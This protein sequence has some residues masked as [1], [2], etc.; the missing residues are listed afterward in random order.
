M[1]GGRGGARSQRGPRSDPIPH[2][3]PMNPMFTN[4]RKTF[5]VL[6]KKIDTNINVPYEDIFRVTFRDINAPL[7]KIKDAYNGYSAITDK[8]ENDDKLLTIKAIE[9]FKKINLIQQIPSELRSKRTIFLRQIDRTVGCRDPNDI[10]TELENNH[11]WLKIKQVTKIRDYTHILKIETIDSQMSDRVQSE[12]LQMFNTRINPFQ[13]EQERPQEILICFKFYK[14]EEHST[15]N[16]PSTRTVCSECAEEGHSFQ[17]CK[18]QTKKCLNCGMGHRTFLA[19]CPYRKGKI[20]ERE[21]LKTKE[22]EKQINKT[23]AGIAKVAIEEVK[24]K[25]INITR[26]TD[27]KMTALILEA[28]IA[29]LS[30]RRKFGELLSESMKL[31]FDIDVRFPDRNSQEI[32]NLYKNRNSQDDTESDIS[33][34][35]TVEPNQRPPSIPIPTEPS[36]PSTSTSS[37]SQTKRKQHQ[38][39]P[40]AEENSQRKP[41]KTKKTEPETRTRKPSQTFSAPTSPAKSTSSTK[42]NSKGKIKERIEYYIYKSESDKIPYRPLPTIEGIAQLFIKQKIKIGLPRQ[43]NK[44]ELFKAI[45]DQ[46]PEIYYPSHEIHILNENEFKSIDSIFSVKINEPQQ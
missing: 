1:A 26:N 29:A 37:Q 28:H 18:S 30:G 44:Q 39:T 14:M 21:T 42:S 32:F 6:L 33:I 4:V 41:T 15:R 36:A 17:D 22:T 11:D 35:E 20:A 45:R 27:L 5:K 7:I 9:S 13:I 3:L 31:N 16:C 40:P 25:H 23:Y 43:Y 19:S 34:D 38:L 8:Q 24:P 10:K 12:G 2:P 46:D